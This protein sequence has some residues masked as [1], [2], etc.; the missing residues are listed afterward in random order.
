MVID[1]NIMDHKPKT[2]NYKKILQGNIGEY[3]DKLDYGNDFLD[4]TPEAQHIVKKKKNT[5]F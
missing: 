3:L 2:W 5:V 4:A 1:L